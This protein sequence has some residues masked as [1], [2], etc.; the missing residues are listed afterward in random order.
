MKKR[1]I[2]IIATV[3][4][5]AL[6]LLADLHV[7]PTDAATASFGGDYYVSMQ[8]SDANDGFT[9]KTS[10][11][12]VGEAVKRANR[13]YGSRITIL[14]GTYPF[15][16][17]QEWTTITNAVTLASQTGNPDDVVIDCCGGYGLS[18]THASARIE[19]V[20]IANSY[21]GAANGHA[22]WINSGSATNIIV[23]NLT[24]MTY[25]AVRISGGTLG[26]LLFTNNVN[27]A[28]AMNG[29]VILDASESSLVAST[30][31]GNKAGG[32]PLRITSVNCYVE[33]CNFLTN[34]Y[35][36]LFSSQ[37]GGAIY[38][39]PNLSTTYIRRC[40]FIGNAG[41]E[42][43]A[44]YLNRG[45]M[46]SDCLFQGNE[47]FYHS[48]CIR[49]SSNSGTP[50]IERC[51]FLDNIGNDHGAI[52]SS[53][54]LAFTVRNCLFVG[55]RSNGGA[56]GVITSSK[57]YHFQNCTFYGNRSTTGGT[58]A[59]YL[60]HSSASVKNCIFYNNGP[61]ADSRNAYVGTS[62][63]IKNTCYPEAVAGN[64][65]GNFAADPQLKAD[66]T[67]NSDSPC[68]SAG[69]WTFLGATKDVVKAQKDLAGNSRLIGGQIDMGCF[70]ADIPAMRV[71][72]R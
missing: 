44:C 30:F 31:I 68:V 36:N 47:A 70:E 17:T 39:T 52:S 65:T 48:S 64:T 1:L 32:A 43:G 49:G 67:L 60:S 61:A 62:A 13:T 34:L 58:H 72:L 57:A 54:S 56:P 50:T 4:S 22:L 38:A 19:G 51:V 15:P 41:N 59:L 20:S 55:N 2:A 35:V 33:D 10:L 27:S 69:D 25:A 63:N 14:P 28:R 21:G 45:G 24:G 5:A 66:W 42:C 6:P 3:A 12:T 71:L 9:P 8:G 7:M 46:V 40:R 26:G 11:L 53:D 18:T 37:Y 23:C 29:G 16:G